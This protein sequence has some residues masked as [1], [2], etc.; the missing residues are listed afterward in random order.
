MEWLG[1]VIR[2]VLGISLLYCICRVSL[3]DVRL[4]LFFKWKNLSVTSVRSTFHWC[5]ASDNWWP[6]VSS[7]WPN[8]SNR[9]LMSNVLLEAF[10]P[11]ESNISAA[12]SKCNS[13][14]KR[15]AAKIHKL[16]KKSLKVNHQNP[17]MYAKMNISSSF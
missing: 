10:R 4:W 12:P 3:L 7:R 6:D 8:V 17:I 14:S 15:L 13:E 11:S 5:A 16:E 9:L 2:Y 1:L